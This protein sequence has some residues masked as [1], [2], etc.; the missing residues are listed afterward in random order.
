MRCRHRIS[1]IAFIGLLAWVPLIAVASPRHVF[2]Y[3]SGSGQPTEDRDAR[4]GNPFATAL[5]DLLSAR[6][7]RTLG[8]FGLELTALTTVNSRG[9][10]QAEIVGSGEMAELSFLPKP[11]DETWIAL[12]VVFTDYSQSSAGLQSLRGAAFD[13]KRVS[14]TLARTG[15]KVTTL[16]DADPVALVRTLQAFAKRSMAADLALIYT[17]GHG[18][19]ANGVAQISLPYARAND[20]ASSLPVTELAK[21][22]HAKRAN[23]VFYAACRNRDR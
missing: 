23:L 6:R 16:V 9:R 1:R 15:F 13:A 18:V 8:V 19:E 22:A 7:A 4:G 2:F 21:H 3:A 5:V 14:E 10:Q 20:A 11:A 17:T 12:V